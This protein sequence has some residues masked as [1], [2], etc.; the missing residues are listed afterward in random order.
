MGDG[1]R[2]KHQPGEEQ[3]KEAWNDKVFAAFDGS[4]L[5]KR[6]K[7]PIVSIAVSFIYPNSICE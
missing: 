6:K 1:N 5:K 3:S 2:S 4:C 7:L